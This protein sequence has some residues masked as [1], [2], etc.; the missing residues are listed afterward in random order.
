MQLIKANRDAILRP[1]QIVAGIV[2][3]R[4]TQ[5]ILANVLIRRDGSAV[6]LTGSDSE[7]QIRTTAQLASAA[8]TDANPADATTTVAARKLLDILR[9]MPDDGLVTVT[10]ASRKLTVAAG[11]SR[12]TLQ[13]LGAEAF[14][15]ATLVEAG[16]VRFT[17]PQ[18]TLRSLFSQVFY[19]MAQQD[20]RFYLNGLLFVVSGQSLTAVATD[21]HRLAVASATCESLEPE[22]APTEVII[23]RK[24]VMELQRLLADSEE[25]VVIEV[26]PNQARFRFVDDKQAEIELVT[27]LVEGKFPDWRRVIPQNHQ[28]LVT[29]DRD[30]F[31]RALTRVAILTGEKFRAVH[32]RLSP[33][34]LRIQAQNAEQEEATDELDIEYNGDELDVGFNVSYL[35]DCLNNLKSEHVLLHFGDS[36]SSALLTVPGLDGFQYVVMPVR[37]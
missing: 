15:T 11:K 24:A 9:S 34:V 13:T 19:A 6:S 29:V 14:P 21:A 28:K 26:T 31:T 33:S 27:K 5:P 20:I 37:I 7:I 4:H 12:F 35:L 2:E 3:R 10:N 23:P 30:S 32:F 16:M 1:L 25:P 8:V 17:V 22:Q 18:G 36:G